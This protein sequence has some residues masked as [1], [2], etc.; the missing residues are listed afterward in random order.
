M[1]EIR[2]RIQKDNLSSREAFD[3]LKCC[4][5]V[6]TLHPALME[7]I[8]T[9]LKNKAQL[10]IGHYNLLL[11]VYIDKEMHFEPVKVLEEMLMADLEPNV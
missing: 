3:V 6:A 10:D 8:W 7:E 5:R 11:K 4:G 2:Y 9:E 1:K